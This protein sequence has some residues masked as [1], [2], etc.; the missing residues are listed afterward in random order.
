MATKF[1]SVPFWIR[2][3]FVLVS[4]SE[5]AVQAKIYGFPQLAALLERIVK[6]E[7]LVQVVIRGGNLRA[8]HGLPSDLVEQSNGIIA[9]EQY[10][11][12]DYD[13][14]QGGFYDEELEELYRCS[15][16]TMPEDKEE[17]LGKLEEVFERL[18]WKQ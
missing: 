18:E 8:V 3:D 7:P 2:R 9:T 10:D 16:M 15:G 1:S 5:L 12:L 11:L 17:A 6:G 13:D 4:V 14:L